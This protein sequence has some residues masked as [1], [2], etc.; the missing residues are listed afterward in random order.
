[1]EFCRRQIPFEASISN[2]PK[3]NWILLVIVRLCLGQ[4]SGVSDSITSEG[5]IG[6]GTCMRKAI[7]DPGLT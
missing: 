5:Y 7:N 4:S 3:P 1:M 2:W 6:I